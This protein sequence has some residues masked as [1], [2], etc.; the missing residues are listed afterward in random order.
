MFHGIINIYKEKGYTSHDVVA[1]LRRILGQKKI[2]HTGTL[3]PE[4]TGVLPVCL[5]RGTKVA[6]MLTDR[7]KAYRTTF[8]L[9]RETD[10]QDH[11]GTTIDEKPWAH[12]TEEQV[13]RVISE[14]EGP[15]EQIPPMFSAIKVNGRKLYDLAREGKS[16][17]RKSRFVVIHSIEDIQIESPEISMTVYCSKG[18]YIRT[19]CRDIA[20]AL[21]SC[22]HM[23]ALERI[24]SGPFA[25]D[26]AVTLAE[27]ETMMAEGRIDGNIIPVDTM[28][29]D[30]KSTTVESRYNKLLINGNKLPWDS[31]AIESEPLDGERF[32]VYNDVGD[33]MGVYRWDS[34]GK[35]LIPVTFFNIPRK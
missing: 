34:K 28:F 26:G 32:N 14:F 12:I 2:G 21:G 19:L 3:D 27:V 16:I 4:A 24:K 8:I 29:P 33:Y 35:L 30:F 7:D 9:G 11:T 13:K 5:G 6:G 15:I 31:F 25:L 23:T 17:E 20:E 18:T 10:T 1:R 22:G